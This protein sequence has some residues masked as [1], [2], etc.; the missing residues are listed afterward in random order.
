MA[1]LIGSDVYKGAVQNKVS[2][3]DYIR[4]TQADEIAD[5]IKKNP[6]C[7]E[8][9]PVQMAMVG[10]GLSKKS[11]VRDFYSSNGNELLFPALVEQ[12][13]TE[14]I[15]ENPLLKML[16][17]GTI[18]TP[19]KDVRT[20]RFD[21]T[22]ADAK[23]VLEFKEVAEGAELPA[24]TITE[25]EKTIHIGKYG[26]Q[27]KSTYESIQDSSVERFM[28]TLNQALRINAARQRKAAV[29]C[30]LNG[31]GNAN[32]AQV[33][34]TTASSGLVTAEDVVDF[35]VEFIDV[36]NGLSADTFCANKKLFK[37]L[38]KMYLPNYN[39]NGYRPGARFT[40]PQADMQNV[41]VLYDTGVP[42]GQ[43][44]ALDHSCAVDKY[45]VEN[46]VIS[47]F[48]KNI[49]SQTEIGTLSERVGFGVRNEKA[50]GILKVKA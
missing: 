45:V 12:Q 25:S 10:A 9:S 39:E 13:I 5:F 38:A 7:A 6:Q 24:V 30:A 36:S 19:S 41:T 2:L 26:L 23:K 27:V 35:M 50:R 34:Y 33:L 15:D 8:F 43:L 11:P 20:L 1:I 49:T 14:A 18:M 28:L 46:S 21:F 3:S 31:D 44:L 4:K 29:A 32:A 37:A 16:L 22:S 47:E 17:A 48:D 40:F 42:D